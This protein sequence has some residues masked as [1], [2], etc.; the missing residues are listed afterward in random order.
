MLYQSGY[1]TI[2]HYDKELDEYTLGFPNREVEYGFLEELLPRYTYTPQ[3]E[4][5]HRA[6]RRAH[7]FYRWR[8]VLINEETITAATMMLPPSRAEDAGF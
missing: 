3:G 7:A 5:L 8:R 2:R 4:D 6:P 1:V